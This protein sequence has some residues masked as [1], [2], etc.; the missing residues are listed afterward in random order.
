MHAVSESG[1]IQLICRES[2][3]VSGILRIL[4]AP[5]VITPPS[6]STE[7]LRRAYL[8]IEAFV[9]QDSH[10]DIAKLRSAA[11]RGVE[12]AV[13]EVHRQT[14]HALRYSNAS[15]TVR[16]RGNLWHWF[17]F[18]HRSQVNKEA[19]K[20]SA[21]PSEIASNSERLLQMLTTLHGRLATVS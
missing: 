11:L 3:K 2:Q 14:R 21:D 13:N 20:M 4:A 5:S 18:G 16:K 8:E 15:H 7:K 19:E 9:N 12:L 6:S 1:Y 10:T 17:S